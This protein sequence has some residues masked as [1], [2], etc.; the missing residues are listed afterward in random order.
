MEW[1][2]KIEGKENQRIVVKFNPEVEHLYFYGQYKPHNQNWVVFSENKCDIN[3]VDVKMI[4]EKLLSTYEVMKK[5][6]DKYNE[7]AEGF[8]LIKVIEI[9]EEKTIV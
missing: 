9:Q 4:K 7:I 2:V 1:K 3:D 6:L 5:R 8:T